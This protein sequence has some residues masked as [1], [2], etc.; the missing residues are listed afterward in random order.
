MGQAEIKQETADIIDFNAAAAMPNETETDRQSLESILTLVHS[1]DIA[2]PIRAAVEEALPEIWKAITD[3]IDSKINGSLPKDAKTALMI[4]AAQIATDRSSL[5]AK[6]I[7]DGIIDNVK[8]ASKIA[9]E[10]ASKAIQ[11]AERPVIIFGSGIMA[12]SYNPLYA[13]M[14]STDM[15]FMTTSKGVEKA[16]YEEPVCKSY[17]KNGY[18]GTVGDQTDVLRKSDC[19]ILVGDNG[20]HH[21]YFK[22]F[23][24]DAAIVSFDTKSH[25]IKSREC[26]A[27]YNVICKDGDDIVDKLSRV[28]QPYDTRMNNAKWKKTLGQTSSRFSAAAIR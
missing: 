2:D 11:N 24:R 12:Q 20:E 6:A 7:T 1:R 18:I 9:L 15:P 21:D 22:S 26:N 17:F 28:Y 16:V 3:K 10:K 4:M 19:I 27:V 5:A 14:H 13:I 25:T 23:A 8:N